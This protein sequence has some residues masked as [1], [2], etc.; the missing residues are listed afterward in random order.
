[1][2]NPAPRSSSGCFEGLGG[3]RRY[4]DHLY[5]LTK[6]WPDIGGQGISVPRFGQALAT[7]RA[8]LTWIILFPLTPE[9]PNPTTHAQADTYLVPPD[10]NLP[11][12]LNEPQRGCI[13]ITIPVR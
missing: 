13:Y 2:I 5:P 1:M 10:T 6:I 4:F 12:N 7:E 3:T 9:K 11:T 8:R